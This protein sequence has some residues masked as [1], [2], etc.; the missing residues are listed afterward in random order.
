M[1]IPTIKCYSS[2]IQLSSHHFFILSKGNNSG[3]PLD[4][5]CPNCFVAL[6]TSQDQK[7]FYYWLTYALWKSKVYY[8]NLYGSVIPFIRISILKSCLMKATQN[9]L[10]HQNDFH[11]TIAALRKHQETSQQILTFLA[12]SNQLLT[13]QLRILVR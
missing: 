12:K 13:S 9:V 4:K 11:K 7:E 1:Q 2:T 5:P 10:V 3:K 8:H 6:C